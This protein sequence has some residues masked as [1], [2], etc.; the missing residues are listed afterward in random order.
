MWKFYRQ[1]DG[2]L[3]TRQEVHGQ[4]SWILRFRWAKNWVTDKRKY[5]AN[6]N[7]SIF[8]HHKKFL[9]SDKI[10]RIKSVFNRKILKWHPIEIACILLHFGNLFN[11]DNKICKIVQTTEVKVNLGSLHCLVA[12]NTSVFKVFHEILL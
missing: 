3:D 2:L 9:K 4:N 8:W 12:K 5:F 6:I 11:Y 10:L 1:M 7:Y